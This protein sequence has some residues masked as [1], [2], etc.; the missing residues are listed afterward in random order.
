MNRVVRLLPLLLGVGLIVLCARLPALPLGPVPVTLQS[1]AV[2]LAGAVLGPWRGAV[3]VLLYLGLGLAGA[4]VFSGGAAGVAVLQ[5]ASA[6]YLLAFPLLALFGG[7]LVWRVMPAG[8]TPR[9]L[10]LFACGLAGSVLVL[11]PLGIAGLVRALE[12]TP[13]Q[14]LSIDLRYW[15][16]DVLKNALMAVLAS[17]VHRRWPGLRRG[18]C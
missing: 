10:W 2:I 3:A 6:G 16:G 12:I 4:P 18:Q 15:P 7:G 9:P 11:H 5:G 13:L 14:A 17:A 1:F 8:S